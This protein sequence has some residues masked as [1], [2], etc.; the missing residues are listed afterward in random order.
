MLEVEHYIKIEGK[1]IIG[2]TNAP[3][4]YDGKGGVDLSGIAQTIQENPEMSREGLCNLLEKK[5]GCYAVEIN[6]E[7][8]I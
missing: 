2:I 7:L 3:M 1:G 8:V 5:Y 6:I 4:K